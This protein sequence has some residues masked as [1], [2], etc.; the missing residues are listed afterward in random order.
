LFDNTRERQAEARQNISQIEQAK[1]ADR[2][3]SEVA[4]L[5]ARAKSLNDQVTMAR[6]NLKT[7]GEALAAG[8]QRKEAGVGVVLEVVQSQ[9][10]L[11]QARLTYVETVAEQN[12][13]QYELLHALGRLGGNATSK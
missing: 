3:A 6:D 7:A 12:K 5:M 10:D 1:L 9:Q 13:V 4:A 8:E 2:L 11:T